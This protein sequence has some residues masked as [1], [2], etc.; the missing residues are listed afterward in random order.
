MGKRERNHGDPPRLQHYKES[1]QTCHHH[2]H[3]HVGRNSRHSRGCRCGW[4]CDTWCGWIGRSLGGRKG[5]WRIGSTGW[6]Q[7]GHIVITGN[8][9]AIGK[10]QSQTWKFVHASDIVG[11]AGSIADRIGTSPDTENL[12]GCGCQEAIVIDDGLIINGSNPS[13]AG[14]RCSGSIC[15]IEGNGT[16]AIIRNANRVGCQGSTDEEQSQ[17]C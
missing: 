7:I 11:T 4:G 13:G 16:N 15:A 6:S 8:Q 3:K 10:I 2:H 14:W 9:G 12:T 17:G 1:S 5:K